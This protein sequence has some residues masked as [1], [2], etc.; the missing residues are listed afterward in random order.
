[1]LSRHSSLNLAAIVL[2]SVL[3]LGKKNE[4]QNFQLNT[5][6]LM[7]AIAMGFAATTGNREETPEEIKARLRKCLEV[8]YRHIDT[9]AMYET[10]SHLGE[11]L[12]EVISSGAYKREDL[13]ITTKLHPEDT[14]PNEVIPALKR[15]LS[16]LQLEYVDMFLIH[17]PLHL[18][19][20]AGFKYTEDSFLPLDLVGVWKAM[21]KCVN[22][23]L[24]K[25]IGVSNFGTKQLRLITSDPK[26]RT[27]PAVNQIEM[28][29]GCL[30]PK[31]LDTCRIMGTVVTAYTP[32]GSPGQKFGSRAILDSTI[33]QEIATKHNRTAAQIALRWSLEYGA[34]VVCKTTNST[35]M[36]QNLEIFGWSLDKEDLE[37]IKAIPRF[38]LLDVTKWCNSTTSPYRSPAELL[39]D[40]YEPDEEDSEIKR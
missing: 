2:G 22:L 11:V 19:K 26:I 5:G 38:R 27:V 8:G 28:H 17:Q 9:A 32:L 40:W 15:S 20:G 36:A 24:A 33:I 7:P 25:A 29:P 4:V 30:L 23:G 10:E 18:T 3:K 37:R 6:A 21:E 16:A 34:G 1:M 31:L 35:R 14:H 12:H 39:E 13:F